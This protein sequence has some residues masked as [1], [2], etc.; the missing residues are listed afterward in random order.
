M[1]AALATEAEQFLSLAR[2]RLAAEGWN[3][4]EWVEIGLREALHKDGRR[5]LESLLSEDCTDIDDDLKMTVCLNLVGKHQ[6]DYLQ[7]LKLKRRAS[8]I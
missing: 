8:R 3:S 4:A 6:R 1:A 2:E 7:C 5:W